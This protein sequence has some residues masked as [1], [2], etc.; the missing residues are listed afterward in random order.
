[1]IVYSI[2]QEAFQ[3][4]NAGVASAQAIVL[5]VIMLVLT[6]TQFTFFERRVHY[7]GGGDE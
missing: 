6:L 1:M 5:F 4:R 7:A 2:Y 3:N